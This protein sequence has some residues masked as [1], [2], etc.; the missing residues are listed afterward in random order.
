MGDFSVYSRTR[1]G[2]SKLRQLLPNFE[3]PTTEGRHHT[4]AVDL[5]LSS[6]DEVLTHTRILSLA[7]SLDVETNLVGKLVDLSLITLPRLEH[8]EDSAGGDVYVELGALH[9]VVGSDIEV[10]HRFVELALNSPSSLGVS[11]DNTSV[12]LK[13]LEVGGEKGV[14]LDGVVG[15]VG[16]AGFSAG[17]T[18]L[19]DN[20]TIDRGHVELK[21]DTTILG[22]R[23]GGV[24][25]DAA[26][27]QEKAGSRAGLVE[28]D[29]ALFERAPKTNTLDT[30]EC[31]L[32]LGDV[33]DKR[34][35]R[36]VKSDIDALLALGDELVNIRFKLL[37]V[38]STEIDDVSSRLELLDN[39]L[40]SSLDNSHLIRS[41]VRLVGNCIPLLHARSV[42]DFLGEVTLAKEGLGELVVH[43]GE[44]DG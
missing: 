7:K 38:G 25:E 12:I 22:H 26:E 2:T 14:I 27:R 16:L 8:L 13:T 34:G 29:V 40:G 18:V 23:V 11:T 3:K 1:S 15:S 10:M 31:S 37:A 41:L 4:R 5:V 20:E 36:Q 42:G 33:L 9:F 6:L 21:L 32:G 35:V 17:R 24:V 28:I 19:A 44:V 30:R 39:L 43:E